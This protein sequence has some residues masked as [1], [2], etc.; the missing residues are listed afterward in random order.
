MVTIGTDGVIAIAEGLHHVPGLSV[1]NLCNNGM[2]D[3][4]ARALA[5]NLYRVPRLS[6][7]D[8]SSNKI[9]DGF[10]ALMESVGNLRHILVLDVKDNCIG[11]AGAEALAENLHRIK[12][13]AKLDVEYTNM[14]AVGVLAVLRSLRNMSNLCKVRLGEG[15]SGEGIHDARAALLTRFPDMILTGYRE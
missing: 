11:A 3:E 6:E 8:V 12:H 10:T 2:R 9:Q 7:L 1:L 5:R 14:G 15:S 13:L 4:G